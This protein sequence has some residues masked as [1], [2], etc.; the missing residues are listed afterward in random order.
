MH[1][2]WQQPLLDKKMTDLEKF[3]KLVMTKCRDEIMDGHN[4]FKSS[5]YNFENVGDEQLRQTEIERK[6]LLDSLTPD[7]IR[8]LDKLLLSTID[9][10]AFCLLREFQENKNARYHSDSFDIVINGK[11][12]LQMEKDLIS[13]N[14]FGDYFTWIE[15]NSRY[16]GFQ[17]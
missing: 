10:F 9:N 1:N 14:L 2:R 6:K 11:T 13:G 16:G 15:Q 3:G 12:T 7:Q 5:D 4:G 17:H 8:T